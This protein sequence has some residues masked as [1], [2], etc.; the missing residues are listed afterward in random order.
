MIGLSLIRSNKDEGLFKG[1]FKNNDRPKNI[2]NRI[3]GNEDIY[4]SLNF[5]QKD[6]DPDDFFMNAD[7]SK[8][9]NCKFLNNWSC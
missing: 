8:I 5:A 3:V 9:E 4:D 6:L 7:I 2:E 1:S